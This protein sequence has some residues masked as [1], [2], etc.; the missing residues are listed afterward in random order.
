MFPRIQHPTDCTECDSLA[1]S[2]HVHVL[3][4]G[5]KNFQTSNFFFLLGERSLTSRRVKKKWINHDASCWCGE[6]SWHLFYPHLRF[7][8]VMP[9]FIT[10][11][12]NS[13]I[14][15]LKSPSKL[16][17]FKRYT[18]SELWMGN[19][20]FFVSR[21]LL[22]TRSDFCAMF[23][24]PSVVHGL[25][26]RPGMI[27]GWLLYFEQYSEK[28]QNFKMFSNFVFKLFLHT[29]FFAPKIFTPIVF[30]LL[31]LGI[32]GHFIPSS[33]FGKKKF[34]SPPLEKFSC[35]TF[36]C[37]QVSTQLRVKQDATQCCQAFVVFAVRYSLLKTCT[38]PRNKKKISFLQLPSEQKILFWDHEW[39]CRDIDLWTYKLML[40]Q[41]EFYALGSSQKTSSANTR[42][43]MVL[44]PLFL[45][46]RYDRSGHWLV[47]CESVTLCWSRT[48][49]SCTATNYWTYKSLIKMVSRGSSTTTSYLGLTNWLHVIDLLFESCFP[50]KQT[51]STKIV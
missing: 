23:V 45:L 16:I 41:K 49:C 43:Q 29:I 36:P 39:R 34:F 30:W 4:M 17:R 31:F 9:S 18:S 7:P 32:S 13:L 20:A 21:G 40:K 14:V 46:D 27:S 25:W 37:R 44:E 24:C 8:L 33:D 22:L 51:G 38:F 1:W 11:L 5:R 26:I 2:I 42:A 19:L 6:W 12:V 48:P 15:P 35:T 50:K 28:D 47:Y 10:F 3:C